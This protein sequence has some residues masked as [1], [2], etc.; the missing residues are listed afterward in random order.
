MHGLK[1]LAVSVPYI[2]YKI[3]I[4]N[5]VSGTFNIINLCCMITPWAFLTLWIATIIDDLPN[6]SS[7]Y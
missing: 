5:I 2:P 4:Y 3:Y 7:F 1:H 6:A